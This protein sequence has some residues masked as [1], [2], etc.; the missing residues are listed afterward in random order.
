MPGKSSQIPY[1]V[2]PITMFIVQMKKLERQ[3]GNLPKVAL[4]K[5]KSQSFSLTTALYL[6]TTATT[7]KIKL[8][9]N[10]PKITNLSSV[11]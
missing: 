4:K 1:E 7:I 2:D 6:S 8:D 9:E 11:Y 5:K 10:A 3:R